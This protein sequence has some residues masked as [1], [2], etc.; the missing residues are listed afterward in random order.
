MSFEAESEPSRT[1]IIERWR[2][3]CAVELPH[4]VRARVAAHINSLREAMPAARASWARAEALHIT[5]KFLGEIERARVEALSEA[6][7]R[8]AA[9]V[10]AFEL[11]I[12]NTGVFPPRGQARVLWLGV[13]D[14]SGVLSRLQQRLD[15]E[16]AREGFAREARGFHPHLTLARLRAPAEA[17]GLAALHQEMEFERAALTVNELVVMRSELG[18]GGSRYTAISKHKLEG[19]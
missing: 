4:D 9:C 11:V 7:A 16:C 18:A 19:A 15:E 5:L 2:I 17:R 1:A 14:T 13:T 6:A 3:F 10:Q 8:A 12:E